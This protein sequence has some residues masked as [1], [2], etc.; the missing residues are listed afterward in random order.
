M[1]DGLKTYDN[2]T[3]SNM[4]ITLGN[5][6]NPGEVIPAEFIKERIESDSIPEG[7]FYYE[8]R[9]LEEESNWV[10]T[11]I[12]KHASEGFVCSLVTERPINLTEHEDGTYL[13]VNDEFNYTFNA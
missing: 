1:A 9:K 8:G 5:E 12:V 2:A 11:S 13:K 3:R 4:S 6:A 7:R 10:F